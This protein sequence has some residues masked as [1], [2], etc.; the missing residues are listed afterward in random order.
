MLMLI[1]GIYEIFTVRIDAHFVITINR[2]SNL[3][4][5]IFDYRGYR[6]HRR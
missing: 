5:Y 3:S 2:R 6:V 4:V 1:Y